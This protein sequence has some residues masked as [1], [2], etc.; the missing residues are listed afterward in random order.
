M[1]STLGIY[2][3]LPFCPYLCPYCDFAKWPLRAS[4]AR[5]YLDALAAELEKSPREAAATLFL[6]GGTP[7]A[8]DSEA[9]S[10][11]VQALR[12]HYALEAE[13]SIEVNPELVREGDF[14]RYR[15]AGVT[16]VSIGVQSFDEAEIAT[17]GRKHS[18]ET[19]AG[20]VAAARAAKIG[21]ISLDLMFAVPGQTPQSWRRSLDAA[22]ALDPDHISTY[23]LTVEAGTP[24]AAWQAREP[25]AFF[26]DTAEAELYA[27]ALRVLRA[28]GY[29]QYEI[30][31][32]AR[33][34]HRCKHNE[35]YWRNGE[36]AGLGVGAASYRAGVRSVHTRSLEAYVAAALAGAPIPGESERLEGARRAGEAI[37]LAL[38]TAQGVRVGEFKERYGVDI[39][40]HYAPV[41]AR[42]SEAGLLERNG[43]YLRLTERGRFVANDVCGAF[44]TFD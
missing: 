33:P 25:G 19:I 5:R 37:M 41:V 43:D 1:R 13:I 6:G 11:L 24:Y 29:E 18:P 16:R 14:E 38:R 23:G 39:A 4:V 10:E 7:N 20:V 27:I 12:E 21:S 36:Y 31:N 26:D 34:G 44:V 3:H 42:Y 30:S 28:A 8:Y 32:F 22:V 35:N 40:D 2:V 9:I 15:E 17:L